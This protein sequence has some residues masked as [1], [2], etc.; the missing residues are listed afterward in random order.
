MT[1]TIGSAAIDRPTGSP[2]GWTMILKDNPA[3]ASG[4]LHTVELWASISLSGC[5]VGTFYGSDFTYTN[6]DYATIGVVGSG[7]K[8][9]FPGLSI[10]VQ[11]GDL[12]GIYYASGNIERS[13]AGY[14]GYFWKWLD[15]FGAGAQVYDF[16]DNR[17]QSVYGEGEELALGRS[18]GFII[19]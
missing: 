3:N 7:L 6:R 15:H 18:F 9:T 14:L 5:K 17:T 12:I 13:D 2:F 19:G 8:R 4:T 16:T 11:T 1:I 10:D